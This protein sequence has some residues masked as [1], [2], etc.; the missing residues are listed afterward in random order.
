MQQISPANVLLAMDMPSSI[1]TG[2]YPAQ[3]IARALGA[4]QLKMMQIV[5]TNLAP[6]TGGVNKVTITSWRCVITEIAD[7]PF[8]KEG[9]TLL[10]VKVR[11]FV[12]PGITTALAAQDTKFVFA[13][14]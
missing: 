5:S 6:N 14:A 10:N 11:A 12:D 8:T 13:T 9:E 7:V 1:L 3:T 4:R 2:T